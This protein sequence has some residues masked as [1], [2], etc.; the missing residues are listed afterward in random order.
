MLTLLT[1][2]GCRPLAWSLCER[3]MAAQDYADDVRWIVVDDG[4][5]PLQVSPARAGWTVRVLRPRPYWKAGQNT[6]ARNLLAG[7][8]E[9]G[10]GPLVVIEDDDWYA[11]T[12]LSVAAEALEH[13]DLVGERRAR[14]YNLA[15][16]RGRQLSNDKHA[17]LCS[18]AMHGRAIASFRSACALR[19]KFIDLD[20]WARHRSRHLFDGHRVV[21]I[22]GLPGRTGIGMG[23]R[24]DFAGQSDP[25]GALL[26]DWL[27]NDAE[28]YL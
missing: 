11:P 12:W 9:A 3:W 15:L 2:T 10:T 6:Q 21:G 28:A 13:A 22:K 27:G 23:H 1:A 20:L 19:P 14:Y 5:E 24:N 4:E 7:L 17:S 8:E 25:R 18:T 16:R 26:R